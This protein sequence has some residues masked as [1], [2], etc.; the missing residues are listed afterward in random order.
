MTREV[1]VIGRGGRAVV[2]VAQKL[3]GVWFWCG[4]FEL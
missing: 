2:I 3:C 4:F 1:V